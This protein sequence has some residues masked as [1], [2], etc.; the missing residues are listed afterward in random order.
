MTLGRTE[1][2]AGAHAGGIIHNVDVWRYS[3]NVGAAETAQ[4]RSFL[5]H[6]ELQ[7]AARLVQTRHCD[8]F[9]A[10]HGRLRKILSH[11]TG[12][13]PGQLAFEV[14][15]AGKPSLRPL[16]AASEP[17]HFNLTHSE[18]VAAVAVCRTAQVGIDIEMVRPVQDGLA[19]RYFAPEETASIEAL[20]QDRQLA[21]F[22]RCWTR[23]EAFVK[24]TGEGIRRGLNSFVVSVGP[25]EA[26]RALS[27]DGSAEAGRA[28]CLY[29]F[30]PGE[31]FSG[32]ICV[33]TGGP[34]NGADFTMR[35]LE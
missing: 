22:F 26:A 32:A 16:G 21:A 9:I 20:P 30:D 25:N 35:V 33:A 15:D 14:S 19:P 2:N 5:S 24:A 34:E 28:Y 11:Y 27:I 29:E 23:K 12:C 6:D 3:L 8:R 4:L 10:A 17:L 13:E 1:A 7:R 18:D 31:G